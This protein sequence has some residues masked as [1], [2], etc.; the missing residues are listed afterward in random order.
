[1]NKYMDEKY[2]GAYTDHGLSENMAEEL[3]RNVQQIE[4]FIV[5]QE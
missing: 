3:K 2:F 1:M 5:Y 4:H